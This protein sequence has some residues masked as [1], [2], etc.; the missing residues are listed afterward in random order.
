MLNGKS[1]IILA[2]RSDPPKFR[3][4]DEATLPQA[5]QVFRIQVTMPNKKKRDKTAN[6]FVSPLWSTLG[7]N[8]TRQLLS[9]IN[10]RKL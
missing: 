8:L 2:T 6:E 10:L 4:K 5:D 7:S 9:T 3:N 1:Q